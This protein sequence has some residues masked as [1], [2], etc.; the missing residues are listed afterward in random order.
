MKVACLGVLEKRWRDPRR[1]RIRIN[2][3][4]LGVIRNQDLEEAAEEFP[5]SFARLN[6]ARGRF[7]EGG[8]TKRYRERTAVKIHARKR[9]LRASSGSVSQPTQPV[10]T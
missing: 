3:D 10:S 1:E 9:R 7:F 5:G 4:R 8:Y 2:D 6:R